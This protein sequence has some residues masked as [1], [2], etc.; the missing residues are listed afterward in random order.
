MLFV[1]LKFLIPL[2][3]L[4][5]KILNNIK[6]ILKILNNIKIILILFTPLDI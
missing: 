3:K 5:L 2:L 1:S 6:I 4:F